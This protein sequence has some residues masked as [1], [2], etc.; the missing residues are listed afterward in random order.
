MSVREAD[1]WA[2]GWVVSLIA[3]L[4]CDGDPWQGRWGRGDAFKP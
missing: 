4:R 1:A 2:C 3:H